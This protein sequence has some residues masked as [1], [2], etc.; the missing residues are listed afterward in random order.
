MC[1]QTF[2]RLLLLFSHEKAIQMLQK[3]TG[4]EK[5][6]HTRTG[7]AADISL[8]LFSDNPICLRN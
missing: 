5:E 4:Q 7:Q 2:W 1:G 8:Q 6:K 3:N